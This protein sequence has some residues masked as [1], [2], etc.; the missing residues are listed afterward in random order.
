MTSTKIPYSKSTH[1]KSQQTNKDAL[2]QIIHAQM[3]FHKFNLYDILK[4]PQSTQKKK[5]FISIKSFN[6]D[7]KIY[8][9][10]KK[11]S[12]PMKNNAQTP[13]PKIS[14]P[15]KI[16]LPNFAYTSISHNQ[17]KIFQQCP[18]S[19]P[20]QNSTNDQYCPNLTIPNNSTIQKCPKKSTCPHNNFHPNHITSKNSHKSK[21]QQ[22]RAMSHHKFPKKHKKSTNLATKT[23]K[24]AHLEIFVGWVWSMSVW[25]LKKSLFIIPFYW[26]F[27]PLNLRN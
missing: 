27:F 20:T 25:V 13:T 23:K 4:I 16:N 24:W 12:I 5:S 15:S 26:Y 22:I 21:W 19:Y 7:P 6:N 8:T 10:K 3:P 17:S 9:K 2:Y 11:S 1:S 14:Y 18:K